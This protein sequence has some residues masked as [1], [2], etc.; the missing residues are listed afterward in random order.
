MKTKDRQGNAIE[1]K[2]LLLE[3]ETKKKLED[4]NKQNKV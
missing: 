3:E 2:S 4:Q 1:T